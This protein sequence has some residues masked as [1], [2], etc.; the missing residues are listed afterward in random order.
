LTTAAIEK[1]LGDLKLDDT[2][3]AS[4]SSAVQ[5]HK[6][7][8]RNLTTLASAEVMLQV[9]DLLTEA[10]QTKCKTALARLPG[11]GERAIARNGPPPGRGGPPRE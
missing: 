7:Q 11:V 5:A 2:K 9:S 1:A 3:K 10:E 6:D 4:V 8:A